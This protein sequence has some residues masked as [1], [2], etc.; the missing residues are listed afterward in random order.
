M[1]GDGD[2]AFSR[3]AWTRTAAAYETIRSM[4]FNA[5]LSAGTLSPT[6]FPP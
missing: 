3:E 5:E 4:P 6:T 2:T 1:R